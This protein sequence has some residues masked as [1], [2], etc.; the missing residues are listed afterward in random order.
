ML[1]V[2]SFK[3][4]Y[5]HRSFLLNIHHEFCNVPPEKLPKF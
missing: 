2:G 4:E 1:H 5:C 3:K